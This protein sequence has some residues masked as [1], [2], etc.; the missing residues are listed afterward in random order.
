MTQTLPTQLFSNLSGRAAPGLML[1]W[2]GSNIIAVANGSVVLPSR[3]NIT[4]H[5]HNTVTALSPD[6]VFAFALIIPEVSGPGSRDTR[7]TGEQ[8]RSGRNNYGIKPRLGQQSHSGG[9]NKMCTFSHCVYH[10]E[11]QAGRRL[12][13]NTRYTRDV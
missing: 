5:T 11:R 7:L 2:T 4:H 13:C 6:R 9:Q 3:H 10:R 12:T 1:F 8:G